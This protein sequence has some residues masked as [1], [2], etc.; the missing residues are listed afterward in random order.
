MEEML[1]RVA[2]LVTMVVLVGLSWQTEAVRLALGRPRKVEPVRR[3]KQA[4]TTYRVARSR[5]QQG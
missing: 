5:R 4:I 3:R 2:V 1:V